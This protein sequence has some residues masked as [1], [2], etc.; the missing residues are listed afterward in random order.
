M[1]YCNVVRSSALTAVNE[2]AHSRDSSDLGGE[3]LQTGLITWTLGCVIRDWHLISLEFRL[4]LRISC[5]CPG[6]WEG[7]ASPVVEPSFHRCH[8]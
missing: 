1:S 5:V 8:S 2:H 6:Y 4:S 7:M 3:S